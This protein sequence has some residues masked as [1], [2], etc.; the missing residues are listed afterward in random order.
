MKVYS[1]GQNCLQKLSEDGTSMQRDN[2]AIGYFFL[3]LQSMFKKLNMYFAD[4][5]YNLCMSSTNP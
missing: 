2:M 3:K 1:L 5:N 4:C